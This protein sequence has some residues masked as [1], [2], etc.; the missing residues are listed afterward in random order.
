MADFAVHLIGNTALNPAT[1]WWLFGT[2]YATKWYE[3]L[4]VVANMI[5]AIIDNSV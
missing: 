3:K 5:S 4:S 1:E 2:L